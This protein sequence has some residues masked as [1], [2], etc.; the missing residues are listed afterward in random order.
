MIDKETLKSIAKLYNTK[1]W[2]QEKHYIQSIILVALSEYP[3]IFKGG[4]YL[5][6]FHGLQRFSEDLDFTAS[7]DLPED[8]DE[9]VSETVRLFGIENSIKKIENK[10]RGVSFRLSAKGPLNTSARDLCQVYVEISKREELIRKPLS[11]ELNFDSYKLPIKI[12]QGMSIEETAAEKVRALITRN[13]ARDLYDLHY[14]ITAKNI[15]PDISLINKKLKYYDLEFSENIF[16]EKIEEKE[17]SW[18]AELENFVFGKL[19][20]YKDVALLVKDWV[21]G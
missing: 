3:L 20:S 19:P 15:N 5:W 2:Q 17:E 11:F 12:I 16:I 10:S 13:K 21:K 6:F 9:K 7:G 4:T 14:L 8:L 1:A 18:K